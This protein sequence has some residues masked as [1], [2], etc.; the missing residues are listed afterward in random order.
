MTFILP[1]LS[2]GGLLESGTGWSPVP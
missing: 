1:M 2:G